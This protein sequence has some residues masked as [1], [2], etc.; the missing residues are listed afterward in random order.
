MRVTVIGAGIM[1]LSTAWA[2]HR[3]GHSV[4]V[5]EQYAVPNPLGSSVDQHRLI[6]YAYGAMAGYAA[7]VAPAYA[8]WDRVWADL[9]E[10]L[11]VETGTLA[12][13]TE[14]H[15]W[16]NDSATVLE[17]AG[18]PVEFL[19]MDDLGRRFPLIDTSGLDRAF[20]LPTGGILLAGKIVKS[21]AR[22]L[23]RQGV[24]ILSH[25]TAKNIDPETARVELAD[26]RTLEADR[27]VVAAG[28]W[29]RRLLPDFGTRVTP[30]RQVVC[31]LK[32]P[33][34]QAAAW[35]AMP[36]VLDIDPKRG[37]YLVPPVAGTGMKI[38]DHT[39]TL[40]GDP[41]RDREAEK[42]EAEALV[43]ACRGRF[44]DFSG[45]GI[46][47]GE[48]CFYTV[49]KD[50]KFIVESVGAAGWVMTGFSGHG[51]KFGPLLGEAMVGALE[52]TRD[53][54]EL[55]HWAAGEGVQ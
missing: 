25:T 43:A 14:R 8:A 16:L 28:P 7:M 1:G 26:G 52:G 3:R 40:T 30:S 49:E 22:H 39:F 33:A 29:V 42:G 27:L 35:A 18:T 51:F 34:A 13:G 10:T 36:M 53:A 21:L 2:L 32:P 55:T 24:A 5:V 48:T 12:I 17:Q 41:D 50:E 44:A 23:T 37:F 15:R 9:G 45:F 20:H 19:D 31:Y 54:W 4:T 6:R 47:G 11:Y 46:E 38:G